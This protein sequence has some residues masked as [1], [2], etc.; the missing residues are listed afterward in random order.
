MFNTALDVY[1]IAIREVF[2]YFIQC[3]SCHTSHYDPMFVAMFVTLQ[4]QSVAG[5]YQKS[6]YFRV[7]LIIENEKASPWSIGPILVVHCTPQFFDSIFRSANSIFGQEN[8]LVIVLLSPDNPTI[9]EAASSG[10]R[11]SFA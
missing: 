10:T 5:I 8:R 11:I 7:R 3:H 2:C 9:A 4:T 6:F 1:V